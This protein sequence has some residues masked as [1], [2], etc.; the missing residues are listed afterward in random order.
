[1]RVRPELSQ[2]A[3]SLVQLV[4]AV[5]AYTDTSEEFLE[6]TRRIWPRLQIYRGHSH[7]RLMP[8]GEGE[9]ESIYVELD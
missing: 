7:L 4:A 6:I 1:M 2:A 9:G 5:M 8:S 3:A